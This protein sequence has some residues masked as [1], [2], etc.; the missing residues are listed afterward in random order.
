M[1]AE[2]VQPPQRRTREEVQADIALK[3]ADLQL[4]EQEVL[5]ARA[6]TR[7]TLAEALKAEAEAE[8][9]NMDVDRKR[10]VFAMERTSDRYFHTYQFTDMVNLATVEQCIA[11]LTMWSRRDAQERAEGATPC[12]MTVTFNS[13]GGDI[14]AGIALFDYLL[15]LRR[16]GHHLTT[17]AQGIA[18]SMAGILLQAGDTRCMGA[19]SWVLIHQASFG[20]QG[21]FG[22]VEDRVEWVKK[23]QERIIGI[24]VARSQLTKRQLETKWTRKDWWLDS[25]EC[26]KLG[27]VDKV[28]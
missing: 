4:R 25:A 17:I 13:P 19:E 10:E 15:E 3:T 12:P 28:L 2:T 22:V 5:A 16:S 9:Y 20:T 14:I 27:I 24:F 1:G 6:E 26:L 8:A 11:T 21:S 18:A 23:V 7:K